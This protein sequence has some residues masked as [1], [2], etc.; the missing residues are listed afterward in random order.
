[1]YFTRQ[2]KKRKSEYRNHILPGLIQ[3]LSQDIAM[4][5]QPFSFSRHLFL[6]PSH[7]LT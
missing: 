4:V 1:M 5:P 2:R 7:W 6:L 3:R